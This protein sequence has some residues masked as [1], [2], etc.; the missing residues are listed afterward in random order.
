MVGIRK[1]HWKIDGKRI[2]FIIAYS[3]KDREFYVTLPG[4]MAGVVEKSDVK[5]KTQHEVEKQLHDT[6]EEYGK[7][8]RTEKKVIFYTFKSMIRPINFDGPNMAEGNTEMCTTGIALE[9]WFRI[10]YVIK[11]PVNYRDVFVD[12]NHEDNNQLDSY[13]S[14]NYMDYTPEREKFFL[15]F[16]EWLGQGIE[17][18]RDFFKQVKDTPQL[19]DK[20]V[21]QK[22]LPYE[23]HS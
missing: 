22:Q 15:A 23:E 17:R 19:I 2:D 3:I 5:A 18:M 4:W 9:L 12:E 1:F 20:A 21:R 7:R 16:R 10:G 14:V 13:E 11:N 8:K 6:I